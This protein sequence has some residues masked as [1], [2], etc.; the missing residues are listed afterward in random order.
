M[1]LCAKSEKLVRS[2]LLIAAI[3]IVPFGSLKATLS[4]GQVILA[5]HRVIYDLRLS[6]SYGTRGVDSV[7]GRILYDFSGNA[8]DGYQLQ[9]RQVSELASAEGKVTIS[10]LRSTTWEDGAAQQFRFNSESLLDDQR[11][12]AV[13][14]HAERR[15]SA[16]NVKLT[17]PKVET[18]SIPARAVFPTE[19]MRRIILAA[20]E[21]KN[22]LEFP[23][24]DGSE[25]GEK[26]YN[27]LTVIGHPIAPDEKPPDDATGKMPQLAKL[28]RW[29]VNISYFDIKGENSEQLGE[30]TPVYSISFELYE[31]GVSRALVLNYTDFV[32]AG[33]VTSL[34]MKA[35]KP[36]P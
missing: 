10:D 20:R 16:V 14:G 36:C 17:K 31:N 35:V 27:T 23:V 30:Q 22:I 3:V 9:F 19:H 7:R 18:F 4:S 12:E 8:C 33:E 25:T 26:L 24:F 32:I 15:T 6:K 21:G 2:T 28:S 34:D 11:T 29:P 5:P 1:T 13:D